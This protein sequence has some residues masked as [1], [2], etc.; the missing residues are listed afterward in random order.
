[1]FF[2]GIVLLLIQG[3]AVLILLAILA[4]LREM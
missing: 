3:V 4:Y 2:I 1:M